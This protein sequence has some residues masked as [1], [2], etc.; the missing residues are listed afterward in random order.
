[1]HLSRV[2]RIMLTV[3]AL[4]FTACAAGERRL[5]SPA[6]PTPTP[7]PP[8]S[9]IEQ[10]SY[11][12][13][14]G[15]V[16][17]EL[18]FTARVAAAQEARLFFRAGGHL[19]RLTVQRGDPVR[20][21]DVLA[22]LAIADLQR[23]LDAARMEWEQAQLES[24]R[25][26]SRT[27][28]TVQERTLAL[29]HAR[30]TSPDPTVLRAQVALDNAQQALINAQHEYHKSLDRSWDTPDQR[31]FYAAM[32]AQAQ[33]ALTVAQAEHAAAA[34]HRAYTLRQLELALAQAELDRT[35]AAAG[36]DPRLA[37]RVAQL[38]AQIAEQRIVAPFDGRVL[39][40]SVAPGNRVE[41]YAHVLI[42][43]DPTTLELR[44]DLTAA[45]VHELRAGQTVSLLPAGVGAQTFTGVIRQ[46]PYGWGGDVEE[47]DRAVRITPDPD[48]PALTLDDLV[49]GT[50]ILE[51][52]A[53]VLWLPP[54]ALQT[55]RGRTF[56]FVQEADGTQRR[57]D[58]T[59]GIESDAR[60]EILAGL[61]EGQVIILP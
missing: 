30:T 37:L 41:A 9:A 36:P 52:R 25:A 28:L 22:E 38:E 17:R 5:P 44:A 55:F 10:P 58:V 57:V 46:L 12:V 20:A 49:R 33:T 24:T 60:V 1:M 39:A 47:T 13:Q 54:A 59:T 3:I 27:Q 16:V 45:Q 18:E 4:A 15:D 34:Q 7:L 61:E 11:V 43:G 29:E 19:S 42:V 6:D 32:V 2:C 51:Q 48:A 8:E 35:A 21:G 31:Q 56:V 40:L 53:G 26:I 50:A 23:Q 14:R